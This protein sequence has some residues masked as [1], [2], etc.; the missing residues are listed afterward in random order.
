MMGLCNTKAGVYFENF[1]TYRDK[2]DT[3]IKFKLGQGD[4][5]NDEIHSLTY[6]ILSFIIFL[7]VIP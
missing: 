4:P 6:F 3:E 1:S 5:C 7:I 2:K